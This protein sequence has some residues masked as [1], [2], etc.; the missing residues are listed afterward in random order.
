MPIRLIDIEP[1]LSSPCMNGGSCIN[2]Q[3]YYVCTC[4]TGKIGQ[5]CQQGHNE[6]LN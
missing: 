4:Q 1:C 5:N 2:K 3:G 6:L